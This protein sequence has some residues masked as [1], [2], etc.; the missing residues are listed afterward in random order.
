[1]A[2]NTTQLT[3]RLLGAP[4]AR[5]SG[6]PLVLHDHKAKALLYYLAATGRPHTR[7]HL[8]TLFWSESPG[9]NARHSL[10]SSLYHIRQALHVEGS[11]GALA[12][13]D[14]L[15]Y[16]KLDHY[17]CDLVRFRQLLKAGDESAL[18]EAVTFYRG[19]LLQGFP[20][21]DAPLFEEWLRYEESELSRAYLTA[22]QRLASW[23]EQRQ[24]WNEAILYLQRIVQLDSLCEE[25]QQ[26]LIGLYVRTGAIG[27][28]LRQYHQFE[29]ELRQELGLT[30]S[31][32]TQDLVS[33]IGRDNVLKKLLS[34]SQS[35]GQDVTV[36]LQGENSTGNSHLLDELINTLNA[37]AQTAVFLHH[38]HDLLAPTASKSEKLRLTSALGR[39]HRSLGQLEEATFWH[40]RHLELALEIH[41]SSA[42]SAAHLELGELALVAN[43]YQAAASAA[44]AGLAIDIPAANPQRTALIARG[45][46]LLGAAL[47]MEG[48]DLPTAESH[49]LEAVAAHRLTGNI[50]DLCAI[51]FE[52]GNVAAQR[53][54]LRQALEHYQE[55]ARTAERT[56]THYFLALAHNN[57]A[58]H[59]LLLGQL[60]AAQQAL[61]KG[62][63]LAETYEM[64]SALLHLTSTQGEIQLY[65]G[66]WAAASAAF[67]QG[68]ALAEELGN[69]ERQ[70]GHRAGLGL[71]A[72]GQHNLEVATALLAEALTLISGR[73]Y[74][75]LHTR[76]QLWLAETLL[77]REHITE[78]EPYL[79]AALQTSQAHG[80]MLL[81]MQGERLHARLL[82]TRN[83]WPAA[84][85]LFTTT[86]E[87]A[88]NL[89][90]SLEIARTQAAWGEMT[91][92]H[93]P[94]DNHGHA[95]LAEARKVFA[96]LD[97]RA[98]LGST[99]LWLA[100]S[101]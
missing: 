15:V 89:S 42:Q 35:A 22:L 2:N 98:E 63:T 76:I 87:R 7:D 88:S 78:A 10:R 25:A 90:I 79:L 52:L 83:N 1:M 64:F 30:P 14:D 51:L 65:L 86:L 70:A 73:G 61:A 82:A 11:D 94:G 62:N 38:L 56:H 85:A 29:S 92:R 96:A 45:H 13:D 27:Q 48:S 44:R 17:D 81:L 23:A 20:L 46:R 60:A 40:R 72:R 66:E 37:S 5:I 6:V 75:H 101:L 39:V 19:P 34:V 3:I 9:G 18:A 50:S 77:L 54:E 58:Y 26:R 32:A 4:E 47:A 71:V 41:D 43:D 12:G 74:W 100:G 80:R 33:F 95:L 67:Q 69:L 99:S 31:P 68:L 16:L 49:L 57:F 91:L 53:G 36:F 93:S 21:N 55:A 28:A 24:S 59:S 84:N 8:A 97:A